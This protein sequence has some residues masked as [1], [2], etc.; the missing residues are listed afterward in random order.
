MLGWLA[1][2]YL[3]GNLS[4]YIAYTRLGK[5]EIDHTTPY[6]YIMTILFSLL[7]ASLT[8]LLLPQVDRYV[9]PALRLPSEAIVWC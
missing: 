4:L 5:L 1:A 7:A 9:S 2:G 6:T 8:L 3:F